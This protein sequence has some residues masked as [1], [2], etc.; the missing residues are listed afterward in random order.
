MKL[1]GQRGLK[2][3]DLHKLI[4]INRWSTLTPPNYILLHCKSNDLT[5][6]KLTGKR[7]T[8]NT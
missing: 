5:D 8:E 6:E 1:T 7:L 4:D 3:Y 2:I